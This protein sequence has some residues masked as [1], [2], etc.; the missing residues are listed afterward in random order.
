MTLESTGIACHAESCVKLQHS[1]RDK[2]LVDATFF[3]TP[4]DF[5]NWLKYIRRYL[6]PKK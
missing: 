1:K 2:G 6:R 3:R 4:A 5:R